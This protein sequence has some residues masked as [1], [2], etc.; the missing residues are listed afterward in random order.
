MEEVDPDE[1]WAAMRK[2]PRKLFRG[3]GELR[4]TQVLE[5][6]TRNLSAEGD[7]IR[8]RLLAA[9]SKKENDL[10][11]DVLRVAAKFDL[12]AWKKADRALQRRARLVKPDGAAAECLALERLEAAKG[13]HVLALRTTKP[14]PWHVLR[15]GVKK[16]RYT[17]ESLLP[18]RYESWGSNLK[19]VQDLLGDVHDL[20]VLADKIQE[21]GTVELQE[22]KDR[23]VERLASER[24]N[25]LETYRQLTLGVA[26]LW[27][28]WRQGLPQNGKLE[29]AGLARL[30]ATARAIDGKLRR[31]GQVS[32]LA[33]RL[34]DGLAKVQAAPVLEER[35]LRGIMR[36]AC[37]VHGIG[38]AL[39][40]KEPQKAARAFL[41]E[42]PRP[43]GW[44]AEEWRLMASIVRY[45]RGS[46]P[47]LEQ[48]GFAKLSEAE[49]AKVCACAG[50]LRLARVL[51]KYGVQSTVGVK[52]EKS[53]DAVIV[54]MP[55]LIDTE[56]TAAGIGAGKHL[57]ETCIGRPLL[58]RAVPA[59]NNVVEL[60]KKA[61][62]EPTAVASD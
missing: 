23:W 11:V 33:M 25:R 20:D 7:P 30:G 54:Q 27:Q 51:R 3:L 47:S 50:V 14:Q 15:I 21:L 12:K 44:T 36:A 34:Y 22:S 5:E 62:P 37:R 45:H 6:W 46:Q 24:H 60:Q 1:S 58:L 28:E 61:E 10:S 13:L 40:S 26:N 41:S 57:L 43:A 48:K 39:D 31:S 29:A 35:G 18:T 59:V 55:G 4:D 32:R 2:L 8:A 19:R 9:F 17:V 49:R 52:L 53:V 42:M 56:E 38:Y 16:F